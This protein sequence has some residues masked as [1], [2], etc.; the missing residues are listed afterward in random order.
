MIEDDEDV[1]DPE[2]LKLVLRI[3]VHCFCGPEGPTNVSMNRIATFLYE[4]GIN[5]YLWTTKDLS[6]K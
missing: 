3:L 2:M 6:F 1:P 5:N 4:V